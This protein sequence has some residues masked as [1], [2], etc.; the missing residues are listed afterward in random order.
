MPRIKRIMPEP[1]HSAENCVRD[2]KNWLAIFK[3]EYDV[4][5]EAVK[6][7]HR[8]LD[9]IGAS[10]AN[11]TCT[12]R[13]VDAKSVRP[14]AN[15]VRDAKNWLAVFAREYDLSKETVKVLGKKFDELGKKL[16]DIECR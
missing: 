9:E 5:N 8:E 11:I 6:V 15:A 1:V 7:L 3:I 16:G 10:M 13:G 4:P 12:L 14:V 2:I